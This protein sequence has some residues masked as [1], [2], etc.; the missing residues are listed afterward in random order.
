M[1]I[2]ETIHQ[3]VIK[4]RGRK[5][6]NYYAIKNYNDLIDENI[7]TEDEPIIYHLPITLNEI[8]DTINNNEL[9]IKNDDDINSKI[10]HN[11]TNSSE[12]NNLTNTIGI[13]NST[14]KILTHDIKIT[15]N[16]KCWWCKN[17]FITPPIQLPEN[18]Y[19]NTFYCIG[20]F[21]SYN[22][23]KSYNLDLN[24]YFIYKRESLINL[25][26][27]ITYSEYKD[28]LLAP[29]WLTLEEFGG[30]LTIQ[31]FRENIICNTKDYL[32]L[33][34]PIISRQM[35]IEESY[36]INKTSEVNINKLNKIYSEIDSDYIIKRNKI[37]PSS[38]MNLESTMGLIKKKQN[39]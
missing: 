28:I 26:Y 39:K 18:Y 4:K 2:N 1:T 14:N 32:I 6:K 23:A 24:D 10:S 22:C 27:Y 21:C 31:Q 12:T 37:L 38:Y 33:H 7:N 25:L 9:F 29:H 20:H 5:P 17:I 34:P 19:N 15:N 16:T 35:Q 13:T 36:K 11:Y 3:P 30:P 8:N